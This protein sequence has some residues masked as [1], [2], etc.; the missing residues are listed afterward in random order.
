M[1]RIARNAEMVILTETGESEG[2]L[3]VPAGTPL[4]LLRELMAENTGL[5]DAFAKTNLRTFG[6][7]LPTTLVV[8]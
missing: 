4:T 7:L 3:N 5:C 8:E 6:R 1:R 2:T